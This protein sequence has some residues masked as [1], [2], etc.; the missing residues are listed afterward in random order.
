[1]KK[2]LP[3]TLP[4]L[5]GGINKGGETFFPLRSE[6][7]GETFIPL[8][9]K[10]KEGKD[11]AELLR[12]RNIFSEERIEKSREKKLIDRRKGEG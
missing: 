5:V 11:K 4:S 1:M 12:S 6:R 9:K 10:R 3:P 7:R 8:R 2:S